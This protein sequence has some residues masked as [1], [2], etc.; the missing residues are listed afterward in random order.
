M[1]KAI[2][3]DRDGVIN[4][5]VYNPN[6][7]QYESPHFEK[8]VELYPGVLPALK[9]LKDRGY[10]LFLISNQP[11]FAKGK[12]SLENIQAIHERIHKHLLDFGVEFTEYFYCYHHPQG[13]I[14]EYAYDCQC[15]KPK[16]YFLLQAKDKYCLNMADSWMIGD[17]DLDIQCGLSA[18]VKTIAIS[19]E[20]SKQR[21]GS[22]KAHF[23]ANNLMEAVEAIFKQEKR[24]GKPLEGLKIKI[25]ADGADISAMKRAYQ[26]GIVK[27]FT[28]NP[29]LM[30]KA[31]IIDYEKFAHEALRE[32]PDLPISFEVL[33]DDF[34]SMEREARKI[35]SWGRNVNV[36]I[37]ITNTKGES[38][39]P[40]IHK[41]S[42][43]G[44]FL[45]ITAILT[46]E[47]MKEIAEAISPKAKTIVSVFAGRI[48]DTGRDPM[49]YIK[50]G[51][52]L[53]KA[54]PHAELLWASSRE[55]LNIFQAEACGCRIITVTDDILNKIPMVGKELDILSL[56]TVDLFYKNIQTGGY[57]I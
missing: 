38:S 21:R 8:E 22:V 39:I 17:C 3:L 15:R 42:L 49:P 54:N 48:A 55:L 52:E 29:V 16:P 44:L 4:R 19:E 25:F 28:T 43:D 20:K 53:L 36:K 2:F 51:V 5:L 57:K 32:I 35:S 6:S 47:Q 46:V 30:R 18:G 33:S 40:L 41:L 11:S 23:C 45:N 1:P 10:L 50:K 37:P 9:Q 7:S 12:T 34:S 13:I 14:S 56:E 31:N 26:E 27:G 24:M